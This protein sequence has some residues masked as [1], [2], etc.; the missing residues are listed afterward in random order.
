[1]RCTENCTPAASLGQWNRPNSSPWQRLTACC[2]TDASKVE[3]VN[4]VGYRV[5]PHLPCSPNLS[6]T[7][8]HFFKHLDNIL[9][10]KCFHNQQDAENAFHE[11]VKSWNMDF[12]VQFSSWV[13]SDSV[14]P[15]GLQHTR[16][17]C[18]LPTPRAHSNLC[19]L[20]WWC[21]PII[22]SSAI[23]FSSC[24]QLFPASGSFPMSSSHQVAK[25]LEFQL[26]RHS[27]QWTLRTD[28]L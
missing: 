1:M 17:P 13:V 21:H 26:Q 25:I 2:T 27:F 9:Q 11:F 20:S 19:P 7:D 28:F 22:S 5:L 15:H 16:L 3:W 8:Y 10:G 12:S 6:P 4:E 18:P 23:P 14:R 24:L